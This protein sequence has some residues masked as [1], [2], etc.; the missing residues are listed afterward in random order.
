MFGSTFKISNFK[1]KCF[2]KEMRISHVLRI[3]DVPS[4]EASEAVPHL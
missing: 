1:N 3:R 4:G 2:M